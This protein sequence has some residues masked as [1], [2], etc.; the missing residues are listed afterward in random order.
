MQKPYVHDTVIQN[1]LEFSFESL[2]WIRFLYH[3][4]STRYN[5]IR[6][7][8]WVQYETQQNW[9]ENVV[10]FFSFAFG[11]SYSFGLFCNWMMVPLGCFFFLFFLF[12]LY[13]FLL[14][15]IQEGV[16][17]NWF[18]RRMMQSICMC[19]CSIYSMLWIWLYWS[20]KM[21][22]SWN[23]EYDGRETKR[24]RKTFVYIYTYMD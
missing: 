23:L 14:H 20:I 22:V 2:P 3:S 11:S 5:L 9:I 4:N 24:E 19:V 18:I 6:K 7:M 12:S 8:Q 16:G 21:V 17:K 13:Y 1:I 10:Y 15:W